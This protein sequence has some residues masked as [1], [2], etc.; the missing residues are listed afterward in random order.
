MKHELW[1]GGSRMGVRDLWSGAGHSYWPNSEAVADNGMREVDSA[2]GPG[3]TVQA[4]RVFQPS[5]DSD[6]ALYEYLSTEAAAP[7]V[8]DIFNLFVVPKLNRVDSIMV[9]TNAMPADL[10]GVV[11]LFDITANA[12]VASTAINV[13]AATVGVVG[14]VSPAATRTTNDMVIRF[15]VT[16][17]NDSMAEVDWNTVDFV[18]NPTITLL[19]DPDPMIHP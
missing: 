4:E 15:R 9:D 2:F 14:L 7:E 1:Y 17:R 16:N 11:E 18:V 3:P 10:I 8:G 12:A 6:R 19:Y 5:P 13:S